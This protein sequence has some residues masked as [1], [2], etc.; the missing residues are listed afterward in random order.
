M[1]LKS[2]CLR[3]N[4]CMHAF[5]AFFTIAPAGPTDD[6][7]IMPDLVAVGSPSVLARGEFGFNY[8]QPPLAPVGVLIGPTNGAGSYSIG[9]QGTSFSAPTVSGMLGL[10]MERRQQLYPALPANAAWQGSTLKAIA[11]N[12]CDD[13]A[14]PGP[15]YT[16]GHGPANAL[17]AVQAVNDDHAN[18]R[19]SFIKELILVPLASVSWIVNS[20]GT[21]PLSV[22]AAWSDPAGP[23]LTAISVTESQKPMLVNNINLKVE[24]LGPDITTFPVGN[25]VTTFLPWVLNPDLTGE[26]AALRSLPAVRG[27]DNRNNVEKTSI[28]APAAG[29]YR[30]TITHAGALPVEAVINPTPQPASTQMVS[31]VAGG[32]TAV[33]PTINSLAVSPNATE[34]LLTYTADPNAF[35]TIQSSPDLVTW[36]DQ[37]SAIS[38]NETNTILVTANIGENKRFWRMRRG[39]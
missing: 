27:A 22:T 18:G 19:G 5:T 8:T 16:M 12:T 39:Q 34:F 31:V 36:T 29:R 24:Y 35:F 6:G 30:I 13:V 11:I 37:G 3:I 23:A 20:A 14:A 10:V 2:S 7:R 1:K 9:L 38:E 26:T 28:A 25:P 21:A 32:V 17:Q 33:L 4:S 15:D